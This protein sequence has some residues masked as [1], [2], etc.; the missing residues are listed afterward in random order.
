M[1]ID[2]LKTLLGDQKS[3]IISSLNS[4]SETIRDVLLQK[5]KK[6]HLLSLENGKLQDRFT[7][8]LL[9]VRKNF[10]NII[11]VLEELQS[12]KNNNRLFKILLKK[13][14]GIRNLRKNIREIKREAEG[15][16]TLNSRDMT[17]FKIIALELEEKERVIKEDKVAIEALENDRKGLVLDKKNIERLNSSM[18]SD[19][20]LLRKKNGDLEN[21]NMAQLNTIETLSREMQSKNEKIIEL[22]NQF[23]QLLDNYNDILQKIN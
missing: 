13:E 18:S 14:L 2:S 3:L 16:G 17:A 6:I 8:E 1:T 19:L 11:S 20:E 22:K 7:S 9:L 21:I 15:R 23:I 10:L 5:N 12:S 4:L